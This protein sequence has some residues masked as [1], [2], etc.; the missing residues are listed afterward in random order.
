M[1][2]EASK[3]NNI[4]SQI[5]EGQT[6][7]SEKQ[8]KQTEVAKQAADAAVATKDANERIERLT[9]KVDE[10]R[11]QKA[12][13]D[14]VS[15]AEQ[16]EVL[17]R[18]N[19]HS[20]EFGDE[21][22]SD[23][24]K[25]ITY[26]D[27]Q[28]K[29][30]YQY[31]EDL[32]KRESKDDKDKRL[33]EKAEEERLASN[34]RAEE[35]LSGMLGFMGL[36]QD[37]ADRMA[38]KAMQ[39]KESVHKWW[40]DKKEKM[41]SGAKS[42]LEWLM[43]AAGLAA[44]WLI[45]KL[46]AKV[47][48]EK[49][50]NDMKV[51]V[52]LL[53]TGLT[54]FLAFKGIKAFVKWMK[55][56][57]YIRFITAAFRSVINVIK[58]VL[59]SGLRG[60]KA[61]FNV[62]TKGIFTEK[63]AI[64]KRIKSLLSWFKGGKGGLPAKIAEMWKKATSSLKAGL[65]IA[66]GWGTSIKSFF[67]SAKGSLVAKI[68]SIWQAATGG[69]MKALNPAINAIKT[70]IKPITDFFSTQKGAKGAGGIFT[71]IKDV[72]TKVMPKVDKAMGFVK[73]IAKTFAKFFAPIT[74]FMAAWAAISGGLDE[75]E[76]E[77]GGFPQKILSFISGALKGLIDFFVFDLANLIQDGIK[78]AIGWFMGLFGFN[79]EEIEKATDFDFVKPIRDAVMDAIDWV[80]DLFRFDG[81][82]VDFS[83]LAKFIDILLWPLN[84]AIKWVRKL[85]GFEEKEGEEFSL[86]KLITDALNKIFE[87]FG[88]LLDFDMGSLLKS[89]PGYSLV[90]G[91][92]GGDSK[93]SLQKELD[94][95][96]AA[97]EALG[98]RKDKAANIIRRNNAKKASQ[99]TKDMSKLQTGGMIL[100]G[101]AAIVGEGS[102]AG[103]MVINAGSAAKVIP[104]RQTAEMLAGGGG[105]Q[106]FAPTTIVNS[107]PTSSSTIMASS[108]LNPISQKYFRS[109]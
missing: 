96:K 20:E 36:A 32:R 21:I 8:D 31:Y 25:G 14:K 45:F 61:I 75:A 27:E 95:L 50:Y 23:L 4:L 86:G 42:I 108:S 90:A 19:I 97:S 52:D 76:K 105:G 30:Q 89:I 102:M 2:D 56:T 101:G 43:K 109:D 51:W 98:D 81:K 103:E 34:L 40:E 106:N 26:D 82:G 49:L 5:K 38:K 57:K 94:E 9:E 16:L 65:S 64:G 73:G 67:G 35:S 88:K 70:A 41:A 55:G 54:R 37:T 39:M 91:F 62:L 44:I 13:D 80:R 104:A 93:E 92:F 1:A 74:V 46:L 72:M 3:T 68:K 79:E 11:K 85:F 17:E 58:L 71:K 29:A 63:G 107:A 6:K 48:W 83:K 87:W 10:R 99:I 100:P 22:L 18:L 15:Q 7:A 12:L 69:V 24:K 33:K 60:L 53:W 84:Q 28:L 47:D 78:W 59:G 77:S 66:K